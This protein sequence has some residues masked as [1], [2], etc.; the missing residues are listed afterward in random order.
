[1]TS[2]TIMDDAFQNGMIEYK[3]GNIQKS[4]EYFKQ[5]IDV[6]DQ[7]PKAWNAL[8]IIFSK[9]GQNKDA[10]TCFENARLLEPNNPTYQK[11]ANSIKNKETYFNPNNRASI[12]QNAIINAK[13][14]R[15]FLYLLFGI[16][17]FI[18]VILLASYEDGTLFFAILIYI[19]IALIYVKLT[20]SIIL[21]NSLKVTDENFPIY[22]SMIKR[23]AIR[24]RIPTPNL[25]IQQNPNPNAYALGYGHPYTIVLYSA[26]VE[27][28]EKDEIEA[29]IAHEVGH[30]T[31]GHPKISSIL[32]TLSN[33][34][35]STFFYPINF[36]LGFWSR[37]A[38]YSAD[39]LSILM[40]EDP[41]T[42]VRAL[43]KISIGTKLCSKI[44]SQHIY[45]QFI[46]VKQSSFH[47]ISEW[48]GGNHPF[49]TNRIYN[50]YQFAERNGLNSKK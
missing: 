23:H 43:M 4:R 6:D 10:L 37:I 12:S 27:L 25:Y 36:L 16:I 32:I 30:A 46:E 34:G 24:C 14:S 40:V 19:C 2:I 13:D 44:D 15:E 35:L 3:R 48:F 7:N 22:N 11:N 21:G 49:L 29:I 42:L 8:G 47:N 31:F 1:M 17:V 20:Q 26:I 5:A 41:D 9:L 50:A 28:L 38:E 39:N 33:S 45:D 18:S